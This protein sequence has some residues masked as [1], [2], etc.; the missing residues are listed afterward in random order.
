MIEL[1]DRID[2]FITVRLSGILS[3]SEFACF[4]DILA[5]VRGDSERLRVLFDWTALEDWDEKHEIASSC[6][7]WREAPPLIDRMAIIHEHHWNRQAALLAAAFRTEASPV[8]SW[9][10]RDISKAVAWLRE[11]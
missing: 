6:H 7:K 2:E 11:P 4:G 5:D 8:R 1:D 10:P 3:S 9:I